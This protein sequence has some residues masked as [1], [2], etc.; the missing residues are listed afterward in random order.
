MTVA[1]VVLWA[2]AV[3]LFLTVP[4]SAQVVQQPSGGG[5]R[6]KPSNSPIFGNQWSKPQS[7][8]QAPVPYRSPSDRRPYPPCRT[9]EKPDALSMSNCR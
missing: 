6:Q 7:W 8:Q 5:V 2:T 4:T 3:V 9:G 1:T